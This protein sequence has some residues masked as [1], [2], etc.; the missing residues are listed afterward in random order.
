MWKCIVV[1]CK[2]G[3]KSNNNIELKAG[4]PVCRKHFHSE[5][6]LLEKIITGPG[7]SILGRVCYK[8]SKKH[9]CNK[10]EMKLRDLL[11]ID[12]MGV[13][14]NLLLDQK[15]IKFK[16]LSDFG[17]DKPI[18]T[19]IDKEMIDHRIVIVF[20]P[21]LVFPTDCGFCIQRT[22]PWK[23]ACKISSSS[24]CTFGKSRSK[25]IWNSCWWWKS[26]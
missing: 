1:C 13:S 21:L 19:E 12:E 11:L 25:S 8:I 7:G 4:D 15:T 14:K 24:N 3:Y 18:G 20:Q 9:F 5:D 26:K 16:G 2:T 10:T 17:D 22:Y 23:Y 6:I